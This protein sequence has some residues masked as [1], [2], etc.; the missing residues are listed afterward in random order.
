MDSLLFIVKLMVPTG[1]RARPWFDAGVVIHPWTTAVMSIVTKLPTSPAV[2]PMAGMPLAVVV[3]SA[4]LVSPPSFHAEV[5]R[6]ML[7]VPPVVTPAMKMVIVA[8]SMSAA[9]TT[10][11]V[12]NAN[13]TKVFV[14]G[15]TCRTA[16]APK[17]VAGTSDDVNVSS[18]RT[19]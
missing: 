18:V 15:L 6:V 13:R 2:T 9:V 7:N 1:T 3:G 8:F 10:G 4:A 11:S 12:G 14:W 19:A 5:A 16:L 17:L